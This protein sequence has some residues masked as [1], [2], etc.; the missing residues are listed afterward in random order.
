MKK[1]FSLALCLM[2]VL[3][4]LCVRAEALPLN[5]DDVKQITET[6]FTT[7]GEYV[8]ALKPTF[9]SWYYEG[10]ATGVTYFDLEVPGGGVTLSVSDVP[11]YQDDDQ[12]LEGVS[13]LKGDV[14][15]KEATLVGAS[16]ETEQLSFVFLPRGLK[17]GDSKEKLEQAF[18]D[19][20]WTAAAEGEDTYEEAASIMLTVPE[21]PEQWHQY[22]GLDFFVK[23][24]VIEMAQYWYSTDAE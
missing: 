21:D 9:Y 6:G 19:L 24:G 1:L 7:M 16:W 4:P 23:D 8:E 15:T 5:A 3:C 20:D 22:Y 10:D 2:L 11:D 17:L 14:L 12:G 13:E 18:P